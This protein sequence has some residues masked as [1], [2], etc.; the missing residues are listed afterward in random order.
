MLLIHKNLMPP[1]PPQLVL[2]I[3]N[4]NPMKQPSSTCQHTFH[5]HIECKFQQSQVVMFGEVFSGL[6]K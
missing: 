3:A 5:N 1:M 6:L 4:D 2:S